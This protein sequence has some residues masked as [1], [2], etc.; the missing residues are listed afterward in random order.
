MSVVNML[1]V[2]A[3]GLKRAGFKCE[4]V[5]LVPGHLAPI[6]EAVPGA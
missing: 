3:G 2:T 1:A 4:G 6:V 5:I